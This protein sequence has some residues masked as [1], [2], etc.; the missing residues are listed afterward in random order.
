MNQVLFKATRDENIRA[1]LMLLESDPLLLESIATY[2]ANTPLH[3]ASVV[4][5]VQNN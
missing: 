2:N 4:S 5:T 3:V 1:L